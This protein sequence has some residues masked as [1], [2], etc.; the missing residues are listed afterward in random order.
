[1]TNVINS[2]FQI[3]AVLFDKIPVLNK[4]KGLRTLL[5]L[6][7]LLATYILDTYTGSSDAVVLPLYLGFTALTGLALN[8][9]G[10]VD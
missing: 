3:L 2:I 8:A 9:K 6:V 4:F 5:G 10:R 7:G 1:M